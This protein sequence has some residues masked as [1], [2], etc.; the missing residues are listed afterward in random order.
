MRCQRWLSHESMKG[1]LCQLRSI[2]NGNVLN[3]ITSLPFF[4]SFFFLIE[5]FKLLATF[6]TPVKLVRS[7]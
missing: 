4:F 5:M 7:Y 2:N 3:R 6:F 1:F